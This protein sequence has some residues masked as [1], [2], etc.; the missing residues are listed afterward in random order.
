MRAL[1]IPILVFILAV[2]VAPSPL[3][4]FA[5]TS[6]A[7]SSWQWVIYGIDRS[8]GSLPFNITLYFSSGCV[9]N[10]VVV[11]TDNSTGVERFVKEVKVSDY[12]LVVLPGIV[13]DK[14][15]GFCTV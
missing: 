3:H 11:G 12:P 9:M 6:N 10:I 8:G 5:Q 15:S 1:Y 13:V 2:A 7:G 14:T 4:T